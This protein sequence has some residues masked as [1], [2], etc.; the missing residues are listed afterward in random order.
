MGTDRSLQSSSV[1]RVQEMRKRSGN[2]AGAAPWGSV[3]PSPG[4][5][6]TPWAAARGIRGNEDVSLSFL[7]N[8]GASKIPLIGTVL[9]PH[10]STLINSVPH[11][12]ALWIC[13]GSALPR[14]A[15]V[16][17]PPFKH[18]L[19]QSPTQATQ[20][21]LQEVMC[22][23]PVHSRAQ[24]PAVNPLSKPPE[25]A[26]NTNAPVRELG[27]ALQ[28]PGPSN[29]ALSGGLWAHTKCSQL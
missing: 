22:K 5:G 8:T 9:F 24:N 2:R 19:L 21:D 23:V 14:E 1:H 10:L 3:F 25:S 11:S 29:P 17:P 13:L 7:I 18:V 27:K 16:S 20:R 6:H 15:E 26:A 12:L 4:H 28:L